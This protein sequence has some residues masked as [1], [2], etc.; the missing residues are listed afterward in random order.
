MILELLSLFEKSM[1]DMTNPQWFDSCC[2]PTTA[3][4]PAMGP[5]RKSKSRHNY[6][7]GH[8]TVSSEDCFSAKK[9][10]SG[11]ST[12]RD[13][14]VRRSHS[15]KANR[16]LADTGVTGAVY[17][18]EWAR[19]DN[20]PF[21]S[22]LPDCALCFSMQRRLGNCTADREQFTFQIQGFPAKSQYLTAPQ[23]EHKSQ[24]HRKLQRLSM[25]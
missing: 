22:I 23:A 13:G 9:T 2:V 18:P 15:S 12:G 19:S 5:Q 7:A 8:E 4:L 21:A 14:K 3:A 25:E 24:R 10:E 17:F 20:S 1:V 16:F 6:G 11:G